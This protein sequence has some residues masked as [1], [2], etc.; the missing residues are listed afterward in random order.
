MAAGSES[1]SNIGKD[2]RYPGEAVLSASAPGGPPLGAQSWSP[3]PSAAQAITS[4]ALSG[5]GTRD[6][7][8]PLPGDRAGRG[9]HDVP[10]CGMA[11]RSS[12]WAW[13]TASGRHWR[14]LPG[15]GLGVGGEGIFTPSGTVEA[16]AG[17]G[18]MGGTGRVCFACRVFGPGQAVLTC[19]EPGRI[20]LPGCSWPTAKSRSPNP[21]LPAV[22]SLPRRQPAGASPRSRS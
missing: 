8:L 6:L 17:A 15:S 5:L 1:G 2:L 22:G 12:A 21:R 16:G 13:R 9:G 11:A 7:R 18:P 3:W 14:Q 20:P 4:L 19:H 10:G